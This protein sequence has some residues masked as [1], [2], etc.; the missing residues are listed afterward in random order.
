MIFAA[1]KFLWF[2]FIIPVM[3]LYLYYFR[4]SDL[5]SLRFSSIKK[6][7]GNA[8]ELR[9]TLNVL[10]P[11]ILRILAVTLLIFALARPQRGLKT[12]EL[13]TKATDILV[14]LDSSRS[15]LTVDFKPENRFAVAKQVVADFIKGREND[16][17]GLVLFAQNAITQCPLTYDKSAL[18]NIIDFLQVGIIP[19]DQTAI[20]LGIANSVNRLKTSAAKSKVIILVTDGANN[21]GSIDPI[22]AAKT[23]ASFG[24]KIYTI[25]AG[26]PEGGYMPVPDPIMGERMLPVKSDLD[27]DTLLR[28]ASETNGKYFRAKT[29][30]A[31]KT[32]FQEIDKLEKTDIKKKEYVDYEELYI[33]LLLPAA[34]LLII[35][36]FLSKTI[37]RTVP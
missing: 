8:V 1:P 10:L 7:V 19:A 5:P 37:F 6:L 2:L 18:L 11:G 36:L 20:G 29:A 16:R 17:I 31:L 28:I 3:V 22:T 15:M 34:I 14:C 4:S 32:I 13:T 23:A 12:E 25:G 21:A 26:S 9:L 27:E 24:I 35:E 33:W 30:G